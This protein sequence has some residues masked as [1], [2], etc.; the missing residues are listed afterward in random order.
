MEVDSKKRPA[1]SNG[2]STPAKKQKSVDEPAEE[3]EDDGGDK[4]KRTLF[5][6]NLPFSVTEDQVRH[7]S[8]RHR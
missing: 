5:V 3:E 6:R 4:D 7:V 8:I 2:D 1:A